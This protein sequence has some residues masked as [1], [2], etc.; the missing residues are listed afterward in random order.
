MCGNWRRRS[1]RGG[2]R[3]RGG[4]EPFHACKPRPEQDSAGAPPGVAVVMPLIPASQQAFTALNRQSEDSSTKLSHR[5]SPIG[6]G[7]SWRMRSRRCC[8][9]RAQRGAQRLPRSHGRLQPCLQAC[10]VSPSRLHVLP[11]ALQHPVVGPRAR[12]EGSTGAAA[13]GAPAAA[14]PGAPQTCP[15][16][17]PTPPTSAAVNIVQQNPPADL[18]HDLATP[19]TAKSAGGCRSPILLPEISPCCLILTR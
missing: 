10:H 14:A 6:C 5:Q 19:V 8:V 18:L 15:L 13:P 7:A 3:A 4:L 9:Q 12:R 17:G 11:A 2:G 16:P 1:G